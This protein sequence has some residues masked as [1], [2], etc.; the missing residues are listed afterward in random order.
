VAADPERFHEISRLQP[1]EFGHPCWTAP[2]LSQRR[3]FVTGARQ[4]GLSGYEYHLIC[5]DLAAERRPSQP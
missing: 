2:V 1:E 4:A 5:Y 3:L